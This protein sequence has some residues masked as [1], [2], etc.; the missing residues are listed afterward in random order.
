MPIALAALAA[1]CFA[2]AGVSMKRSFAGNSL[3]IVLMVALP[4]VVLGTGLFILFD[5]PESV[6][7]RS[8]LWFIAGGVVGDGV[9]RASYMG[10]VD[11]LGVARSTPLQT[12]A[13]PAVALFGGIL[14]FS[15]SVTALRVA[16]AASIVSG[17]WAVVGVASDGRGGAFRKRWKWTW[18]Y[19]WPVTAGL[20][21]ALSDVFRKLA[22]EDTPNPAFGATIGAATALLVW[23]VV[24][25]LV[26]S[27]RIQ[28]K[29]GPG[30]QWAAL[31]GVFIAIGLMSVF[32][33]LETGDISVVGP[34]IVAQPLVVVVLSALFLRE[35]EVVTKRTAVGAFLTVL[36][37]ILLALD[38]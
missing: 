32:N 19:L 6:T 16:G 9:G 29:R 34:V 20:T 24:I 28:A 27:L 35:H 8:V 18:A 1:I 37:V 25:Y 38:S 23:A 36:G 30:W 17:I 12:A 13:Y 10:G 11:R 21:F 31:A 2:S 4:V 5:P 33:A 14:L 7:T 26:P 3:V 15:E 22:L